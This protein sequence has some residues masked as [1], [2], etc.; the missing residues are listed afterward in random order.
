MP[1]LG[2]ADVP[3]AVELDVHPLARAAWERLA[4]WWPAQAGSMRRM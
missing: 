4:A 2:A 3:A 1:V